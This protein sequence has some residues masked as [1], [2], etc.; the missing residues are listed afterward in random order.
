MLLASWDCRISAYTSSRK[1]KETDRTSRDRRWLLYDAGTKEFS[2]Y[3]M[4]TKLG[5]GAAGG[6]TM[7]NHPDGTVWYNAIGNNTIL[8]FNP[9]TKEFSA[10]H[11]PSGKGA[12]RG[13]A[14]P[15]GM[16]IAGDGKV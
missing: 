14:S 10:F 12:P 4:S 5:T 15:Y 3:P 13:S 1:K 11:P 2:Q 16:A 6:N 8:R 9:V 7:R